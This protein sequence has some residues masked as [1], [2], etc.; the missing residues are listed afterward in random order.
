MFVPVRICVHILL[1]PRLMR[2]L[3]HRCFVQLSVGQFLRAGCVGL[4]CQSCTQKVRSLVAKG[5]RYTDSSCCHDRVQPQAS[6]GGWAARSV[7]RLTRCRGN[8]ALVAHD[9]P[10]SVHCDIAPA[11]ARGAIWQRPR[12]CDAFGMIVAENFLSR[13]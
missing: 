5:L 7:S 8:A 6:K 13:G 2:W 10:I 4:Q 3:S 9:V 1:F 11:H 12:D